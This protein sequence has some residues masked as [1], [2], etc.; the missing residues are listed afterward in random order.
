[1]L[2]LTKYLG[3]K[4]KYES[5]YRN[6]QYSPKHLSNSQS[7]CLQIIL[8]GLRASKQYIVSRIMNSSVIFLWADDW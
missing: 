2:I 8:L 7:F 4:M 5:D 6:S 3:Q 1:M